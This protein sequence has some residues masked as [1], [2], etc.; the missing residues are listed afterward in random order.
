M[1]GPLQ[2]PVLNT[3]VREPGLMV[4]SGDEEPMETGEW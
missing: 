1:C 4:T 3:H 2:Q